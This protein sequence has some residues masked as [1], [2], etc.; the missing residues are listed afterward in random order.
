MNSLGFS[1]F[2]SGIKLFVFCFIL[3]LDQSAYSQHQIIQI[4]SRENSYCNSTCTLL[5]FPGL[6][7]N[8]AALVFAFP[9]MLNGINTY[10][11]PIDV[12]FINEKWA[13][14]NLDQSAMPAGSKCNVQYFSTPDPSYQFTHQLYQENP[15]DNNTSSVIDHPGH[16]NNPGAKFQFISN[17]NGNGNNLYDINIQYDNTTGQ[18]YIHNTHRKSLDNNIVFNIFIHQTF[19]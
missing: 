3:L 15:N 7:K 6:K 4:A 13:I 9:V 1:M 19:L 12:H 10:P 18:W 14:I 2:N 8:P 17:G 5:D 11:Y 16:N